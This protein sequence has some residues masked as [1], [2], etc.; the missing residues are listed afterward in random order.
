MSLLFIATQ[1]YPGG[2]QY[3]KNS[4]GYDWKNNYLSNLFGEKAVNGSVNRSRSWAIFG[5]LFLCAS[6]A[7]FFIEFSKKIPFNGPSKIIR[8]SGVLAMLFAFLTVT[9]YHDIMVTIAVTLALISMFYITV[10]VLKSRLH[11]FKILSIACLFTFYCGNYVYYTRN[12]LEILPILQKT[13][14]ALTTTWF[15]LLQYFTTD[16]DFQQGKDVAIKTDE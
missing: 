13:A 1:N 10:F 6:F 8:Y 14:L 16:T 12:Y 2:S 5:M 4:I 3:D 7:L 9:P 15:L 11:L